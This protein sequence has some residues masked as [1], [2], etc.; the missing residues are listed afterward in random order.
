LL[1]GLLSLLL[2]QELHE[3]IEIHS[4]Y[5]HAASIRHLTYTSSDVRLRLL[6]VLLP[7]PGENLKPAPQGAMR[8]GRDKIFIF[9]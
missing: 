7:A 4:F 2:L 9:Y 3:L 1:G 8:H 6:S 5:G